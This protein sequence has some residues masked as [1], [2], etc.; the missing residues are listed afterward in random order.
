MLRALLVSVLAALTL[1][2]ASP[3]LTVDVFAAASLKEAVD[4][5]AA[6]YRAKTGVKIRATYAS[7]AQLAKQIDQGAPADLFIS[8][9]NEW[10]DWSARRNLMDPPTRRV[11]ASNALVLV[12]PRDSKIRPFTLARGAP[13]AK[14]ADGGRIA[15]G[16]MASVPAGLYAKSAFTR[17]GIWDQVK[18]YL[19]QGENV[20]AAL[21]FVARGEAPL[22][23][24]YA[25]DAKAEPKVKV[26]A[27]FPESSHAPIVYPAA[28]VR[29]SKQGRA[30]EAFLVY[31]AGPAG[32][33]IF[34][35]RG[36]GAPR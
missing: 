7:S 29:A 2:A 18:D 20:R 22:G 36:F 4:D 19:A 34:K 25:T 3:P 6:A 28:V 26:I 10:M 13:L 8:A 33:A 12:A 30:A 9:D 23:V 32:Q 24:V 5:A 17:L 27:V 16:D 15:V 31:L 11:I 21:A 14:L 35:R 1:G